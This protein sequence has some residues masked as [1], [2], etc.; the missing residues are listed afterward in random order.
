[1]KSTVSMSRL[2]VAVLQQLA[3]RADVASWKAEG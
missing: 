1:M 2:V 3:M